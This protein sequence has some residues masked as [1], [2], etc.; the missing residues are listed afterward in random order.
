MTGANYTLKRKG[1]WWAA[2]SGPKKRTST[3]SPHPLPLK[4]ERE[5][6]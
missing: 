1:H 6:Q 2:T 4:E 3:P 5:K